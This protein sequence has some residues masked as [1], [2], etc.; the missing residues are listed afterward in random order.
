MPNNNSQKHSDIVNERIAKNTIALYIRMA[1]AMLVSLY[2]SRVVL[3]ALGVDDFGIYG[4]VGGL[5]TLFA[6]I[7]NTLVGSLQRFLNYEIGKGM[8]NNKSV[9]DVFSGGFHI[10]IFFAICIVVL[11]ETIGLYYL[12]N[13]V[14]LPHGRLFAAQ[15]VYQF[16]IVVAVSNILRAPFVASIIAY[17]EMAAY[18]LIGIMEVCI[19]LFA[20]YTL[21]IISYDRLIVYA[22]FVAIISIAIT[23]CFYFYSHKR[24]NL[25]R[26]QTSIKKTI[27]RQ[28]LS[29]TGW[30]FL[31]SLSLLASL[32]GV[33]LILN[34]YYGVAV[35]AAMN[36]A[37][38]VY[39]AA[40]SLTSNFQVA[41]NPQITK[42]YARGCM[43][44]LYE[45]V[46]RTT[47]YS[48]FLVIICAIPLLLECGDLLALWLE[49]VPK[50]ADELCSY[51][52]VICVVDA[53]SAPLWMS[54][55]ATGI[56]K[57][58]QTVICGLLFLNFPITILCMAIGL[59]PTWAVVV[60]FIVSCCIYVFRIIYMSR[61]LY[62]PISSYFNKAILPCLLVL[63]L[64]L[65]IVLV[66]HNSVKLQSVVATFIYMIIIVVVVLLAGLNNSERIRLIKVLSSR[67]KR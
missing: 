28:M 53:L 34:Y 65:L 54:V 30:N 48:F 3:Q 11:A 41:F 23:G 24:F 13:Y 44:E 25:C 37:N 66:L 6:F 20:V 52:I 21:L 45:L 64:S 56:I 2:T 22:C 1:F 14:N 10:Q 39:G 50:Y 58:Y 26:I 36:I 29:F 7:N 19:K 38:Q 8:P 27:L 9:T 15:C 17:E 12:N 31:G 35:N 49:I 60:R 16:S 67:I 57:T 40:N 4:V 55:Q 47:R 51:L 5:V 46:Y 62:M 33:D 61:N 18:A 63:V 42:T 43:D 32:Q 59:S